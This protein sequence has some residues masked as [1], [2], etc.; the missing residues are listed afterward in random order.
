MNYSEDNGEFHFVGVHVGNRVIRD[1]PY[2]VDT[3]GIGTF[4]NLVFVSFFVGTADIG[5]ALV[6]GVGFGLSRVSV[7][8]AISSFGGIVTGSE[9]IEG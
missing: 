6:F 3:E 9:E 4:G 7:V 2:R 5:V 8:R 1:G